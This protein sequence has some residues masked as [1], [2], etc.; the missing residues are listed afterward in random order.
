MMCRVYFTINF[1]EILKNYSINEKY[2]KNWK[3]E[4]NLNRTIFFKTK[5]TLKL[6][7][8]LPGNTRVVLL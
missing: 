1:A 2:A 5:R 7:N 6:N 3:N 8:E 4:K